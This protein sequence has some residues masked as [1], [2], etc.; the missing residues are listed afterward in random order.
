M[1]ES[2]HMERRRKEGRKASLA[3]G[4][5]GTR[6]LSVEVMG[7]RTLMS[8]TNVAPPPMICFLKT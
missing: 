1:I 4:S 7:R 2:M 3:T 8:G 6:R 5:V